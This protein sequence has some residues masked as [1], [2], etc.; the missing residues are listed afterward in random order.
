M[1]FV[2]T[3]KLILKSTGQSKGPRIGQTSWK[4]VWR[5]EQNKVEELSLLN[6]DL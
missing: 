3:H 5:E 1:F 6:M 2:G 4:G